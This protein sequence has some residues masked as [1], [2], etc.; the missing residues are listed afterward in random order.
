GIEGTGGEHVHFVDEIH[1]EASDAGGV[2]DVF[3]QLAGI[4]D[5][6]AAGRID[7]DGVH[8]TAFTD[9]TT[10][11]AFATGSGTDAFLAVEATGKD[12][13]HRGL[14][15]TAGAGEQVGV[16]QTV[17]VQRVAQGTRYLLLPH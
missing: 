2:L 11:T 10:G 1:L 9:G 16:V 15:N 14:A 7:F 12:A 4:V 3:E 13:R 5:A 17:L 6:G 8:E